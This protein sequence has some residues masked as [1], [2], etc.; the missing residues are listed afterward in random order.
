MLIRRIKRWLS[1][2][3]NTTIS[4]GYGI[5]TDKPG[6]LTVAQYEAK[7]ASL[8]KPVKRISRVTAK[9]KLSSNKDIFELIRTNKNK[10]NGV[11]YY[12]L[13]HLNSGEKIHVSK[14]IFDIIFVNCQGVS[15]V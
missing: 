1:K 10:S 5:S 11:A 13:H 7:V 2:K 12:T 4:N 9:Y 15:H 3:L 6:L 8:R 14:A